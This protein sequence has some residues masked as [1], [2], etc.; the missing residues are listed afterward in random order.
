M[1]QSTIK[2]YTDWVSFYME[3]DDAIFLSYRMLRVSNDLRY[4]GMPYKPIA[5]EPELHHYVF[6]LQDEQAWQRNSPSRNQH[7]HEKCQWTETDFDWWMGFAIFL[8]PRP[9]GNQ[10]PA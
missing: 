9:C 8:L 10:V 7:R 4:G 6:G 3:R 2:K 5:N 1:S